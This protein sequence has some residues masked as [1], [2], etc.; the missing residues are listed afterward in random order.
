MSEEMIATASRRILIVEEQLQDGFSHHLEYLQDLVD[1]ARKNGSRVKVLCNRRASA[2]V[3]RALEANPVLFGVSNS[4]LQHFPARRRKRWAMLS[5]IIRNGWTIFCEII[6]NPPY[7]LI[8]VPTAWYPH[9]LSIF[10]SML[11]CRRKMRRVAM[12]FLCQWNMTSRRSSRQLAWLRFLLRALQRWHPNVYYFAQTEAAKED[13]QEFVGPRVEYAPDVAHS[14]EGEPKARPLNPAGHVVFG[15][16]GFARY[17]QGSDVLLD[18]IRILLSDQPET[19][20]TFH[21]FWSTTGFKTPEGRWIELDPELERSGKVIFYR[22]FMPREKRLALLEQLDWVI[23][24]YRVHP[25]A[26]RSSQVAIDAATRGIPAVYTK[27]TNQ[28]VTFSQFGVGLGIADGAPKDLSRTILKACRENAAFQELA[29]QKAPLA[30]S[31]FSPSA[32]WAAVWH[33]SPR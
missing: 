29:R 7:D 30:R 21:V 25:Y 20:A 5:G 27:G 16:L 2:E 22:S 9:V 14:V 32:F 24:P 28:E 19:K 23:L 4:S 10:P 13:L 8:L 12:Q 33:Q 17:E 1:D 31:A 15:F 6:A 11:I 26:K 18:A 3:T